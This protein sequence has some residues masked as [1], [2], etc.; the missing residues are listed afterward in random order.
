MLSS[1]FCVVL[2]LSLK[3]IKKAIIA[4]SGDVSQI[5]PVFAQSHA[6]PFGCSSFTLD[7]KNGAAIKEGCMDEMKEE[8]K[9]AQKLG[10]GCQQTQS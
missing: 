2:L 8:E 10:E 1:G 9:S 5:Q 7:V 3:S 4:S 6:L